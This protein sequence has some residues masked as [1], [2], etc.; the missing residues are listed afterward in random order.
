MKNNIYIN[1]RFL[2]YIN[3][4]FEKLKRDIA[5]LINSFKII[6]IDG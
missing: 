5:D 4:L 6:I 1:Q 2:L 3:N